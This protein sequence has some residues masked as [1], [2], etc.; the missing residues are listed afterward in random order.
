MA[1]DIPHHMRR[2]RLRASLT[3]GEMARLVGGQSPATVCQYEGFSREPDLRTALAYQ[4]IFGV[5]VHRLFPGV[6]HEVEKAVTKRAHRLSDELGKVTG[7][8]GA[9]HKKKTLDA[10]R[11]P[12]ADELEHNICRETLSENHEC[13]PSPHR[14]P[15][16]PMSSFMD[17]GSRSTGVLSGPRPTRTPR[18]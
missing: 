6:Y 3:Q 1:K 16:S 12:K 18:A 8:P 2:Y 11:R 13:L 7:T 15:V 5:P 14:C 9:W 10:L 17:R 4:L